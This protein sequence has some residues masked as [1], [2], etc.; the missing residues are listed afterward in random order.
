M[1]TSIFNFNWESHAAA[2]GWTVDRLPTAED[3]LN[4]LSKTNYPKSFKD[5]VQ[6]HCSH[7]THEHFSRGYALTGNAL[8]PWYQVVP[9]QPWAP[10][11]RYTYSFGGLYEPLSTP[12]EIDMT[13]LSPAEIE[14]LLHCYY[15]PEKHPRI[16]TPCVRACLANLEL[17]G[18][19]EKQVYKSEIDITNLSTHKTTK[20][21]EAHINQL[22]NLP[23]PK[24]VWADHNGRIIE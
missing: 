18:L 15:S 9:R 24:L 19:I 1:D 14:V 7:I 23:L 11:S 12:T 13:K 22:C 17:C 5:L 16:D 3:A 20:R 6:I 21:G 2:E 10:L 4:G 8:C